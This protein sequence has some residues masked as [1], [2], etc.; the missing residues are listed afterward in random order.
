VSRYVERKA[1]RANLVK[2]A[3]NWRWSRLWSL[4]LARPEKR[5]I[6]NTNNSPKRPSKIKPEI[7]G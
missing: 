3:E 1:L 5:D 7:D 2:K 6:V 4:N